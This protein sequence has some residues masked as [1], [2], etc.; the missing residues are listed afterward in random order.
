MKNSQQLQNDLGRYCQTGKNPPESSKPQNM[1]HYRR[2]VYNIMRDTL[3]RAFPI[4]RHLL[5]KEEWKTL[6][7]QFF[8]EHPIPYPQVWKMSKAF[9]EYYEANKF[10]IFE[11]YPFLKELFTFEWLEIEVFMMEDI[12]SGPFESI[13]SW[14]PETIL[15]GNPEI[16]IQV[17]SYPF[18]KKAV[19]EINSSDHGQY[20]VS[21]HRDYD[22]KKVFFNEISLPMLDIL[23][24]L[25]EKNTAVKDLYQLINKYYKTPLEVE[26]A[27]NELIPFG[28]NNGLILGKVPEIMLNN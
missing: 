16:K 4:S 2:L 25:N 1:K 26:Q 7:D 15:V 24:Q 9:C 28:I 12:L 8:A 23:V 11:K 14:K 19:K 20:L 22:S 6:C 18:Y 5:E 27:I 10:P 13:S 3:D 21:I 17:L